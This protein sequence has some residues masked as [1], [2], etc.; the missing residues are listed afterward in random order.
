MKMKKWLSLFLATAL[1][2]SLLAGCGGSQSPAD[3][4]GAPAGSEPASTAPAGDTG[5]PDKVYTLRI[6]DPNPPTAGASMTL[7]L[8]AKWLPEQSGGRLNLEVYHNATL[9]NIAD[10]VTNCLSGIS[11]GFWSAQALY[12]GSF[13]VDEVVTLPMLGIANA[14]V[15]TSVLMDL[16]QTTDYMDKSYYGNGLHPVVLHTAS[17][18]VL[19]MKEAGVRESSQLKGMKLRAVGGVIADFYTAVGASP[20][21]ISSNEQYEAFE[22]NIVAGGQNDYDKIKTLKLYELCEEIIEVNTNVSMLF[23][24]LRK[25]V[26]DGLPADLQQLVDES[27]DYYIENVVRIYGEED[28]KTRQICRDAGC[29]IVP[30]PEKMKAEWE[31]AAESVYGI[32]IKAM[33]DKGYDGQAIFDKGR[34]LIA[35]Y[36][37]MYA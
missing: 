5:T 31:A 24:V 34:E 10:C 16:L 25:D 21:T 2:F 3:T 19:I 11:D 26:Y 28:E 4:G 15:G 14:K 8:L 12:P 17:P 7:D 36:N 23:Y 20:V 37:E 35:K 9:G 13:P 6:D 29:E 1:C 18:V 32:W 27:A 30:M 33:N 22:K